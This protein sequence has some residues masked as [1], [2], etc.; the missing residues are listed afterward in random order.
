MALSPLQLDVNMRLV[1][2]GVEVEVEKLARDT[3]AKLDKNSVID[4]KLNVAKLESEL[5]NARKLLKA[6]I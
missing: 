1:K 6:S 5:A 4:M 2:D 3:K